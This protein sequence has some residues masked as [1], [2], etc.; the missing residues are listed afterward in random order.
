[1]ATVKEKKKKTVRGNTFTKSWK[2][3]KGKEIKKGETVRH[4][5]DEGRQGVVVAR[6]TR[7]KDRVPMVLI[8]LAGATGAAKTKG[9]GKKAGPARTSIPAAEAIHVAAKEA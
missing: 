8:E 4:K 7:P 9:K 2:S 5:D 6:H 1:M 3:S